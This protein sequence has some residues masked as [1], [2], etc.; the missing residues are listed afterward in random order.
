MHCRQS[1]LIDI[2]SRLFLFLPFAEAHALSS[3]LGKDFK[4]S[5]AQLVTRFNVQ[6]ECI[7]L[8]FLPFFPSFCLPFISIINIFNFSV[9][10]FPKRNTKFCCEVSKHLGIYVRCPLLAPPC[11]L[12]RTSSVLSQARDPK[13]VLGCFGSMGKTISNSH[14]LASYILV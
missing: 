4:I 3:E 12:D 13:A 10:V 9:L 14:P 11:T 6:Y 7:S 5:K 1:E 8:Y 2:F